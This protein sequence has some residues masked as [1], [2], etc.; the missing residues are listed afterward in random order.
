M[1]F[2]KGKYDEQCSVLRKTTGGSC[3]I[4]IILDGDGGNGFSVQTDTINMLDA[5]PSVLRMV[6]NS[7]EKSIRDGEVEEEYVHD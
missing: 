2:E 3:A 7:I 5:I 4:A 6:A 1:S